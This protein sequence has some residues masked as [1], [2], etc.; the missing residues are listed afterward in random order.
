MRL[1]SEY[2]RKMS[3]VFL[4][5]ADGIGRKIYLND[6]LNEQNFYIEMEV[7]DPDGALVCEIAM[8]YEQFVRVLLF[9][10]DVPVTLLR[11]RDK[12]GKLAE[13]KVPKPDTA[14]D[15]LLKDLHGTIGG[16][17]NRITDM[18]KDLY[19]LL[20]SNKP[21]GKKKIEE[22]FREIKNIEEN[23]KSNI[24]FVTG[25]AVKKVGEVQDNVKS[26]L[27]IAM[28]QLLGSDA[29]KPENFKQMIDGNSVMALPDYTAEPVA[30]DYELKEREEKDIDSMTNM[31]L[32][33]AISRYLKAIEKAEDRYLEAHPA[34]DKNDNRKELFWSCASGVVGGVSITNISY[35]GG[36]KID[37][38]KARR[39][40]KFLKTVKKYEDFKTHYSFER[41]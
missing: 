7:K 9:S 13:E 16:L 1:H 29:F 39:Y 33:D 12:D 10:G 3:S 11:Y 35:H 24:P 37:T 2:D 38:E 28:N 41:E 15:S 36:R 25:E 23:Y 6:T 27:T 14:Q 21:V 5:Q 20:N 26:Q 31:E 34:Q 30:D 32:G 40:L 18:R 19:E 22:L 4:R 17:E 8:S